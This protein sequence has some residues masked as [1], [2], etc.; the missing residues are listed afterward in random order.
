MSETASVLVVSQAGIFIRS[1]HSWRNLLPD[2]SRETGIVPTAVTMTARGRIIAG[3]VGGTMISD[4]RG[5]TWHAV[6]FRV[7]APAIS[8]LLASTDG[9]IVLAATLE[10]GVF[11]SEDGGEHWTAWN[12]GLFDRCVLD[13]AWSAGGQSVLALTASGCFLSRNT[14]KTWTDLPLPSG[15]PELVAMC[16]TND[17]WL[18]ATADGALM[19]IDDAGMVQSC[20]SHDVGDDIVAVLRRSDGAIAMVTGSGTVSLFG[21]D[22]VPVRTIPVSRRS[23]AFITCA[24]IGGVSLVAGWSDGGVTTI[25][26]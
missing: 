12:F 14:G 5:E 13:L 21:A 4:D 23:D 1:E 15:L 9:D 16:A 24:T 6:P 7:P 10:D 20:Q 26:T 22:F 11:R 19:H 2:A 17:G 25:D 3:V 8:A 18:V